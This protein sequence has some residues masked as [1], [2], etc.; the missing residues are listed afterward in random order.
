MLK[1]GTLI[2]ERYEIIEMIGSGGMANVYKAKDHKLNRFVALKVLKSEFSDDKNFVK[3]FREE[4]QACAGLSHPNIVNIYDVGNDE[5]TH[6]IV[7]ELVE[8]ITLKSYI[9]RK[10]KLEI[11]EAVGIAIQIARGMEAAHVNH[12]VHRDIKPQNIILSREGKVKVTDFGIAKAVNSNTITA[13]TMGSV[14]YLSPEQARGGYSDE[15]S[16]IYS[17]GVTLYEMLSG[18]VP[19]IGD[20]TVSVALLHIQSEAIPLRELDPEIPVS[21]ERIVQKCMQKKPERRYLTASD[22]IF[23]LR[24]SIDNPNGDFV[25]IPTTKDFDSPTILMSEEELDFIKSST[26]HTIN[27]NGG[28]NGMNSNNNR[29]I[30]D[31]EYS[32]EEYDDYEEYDDEYEAYE[33]DDFVEEDAEDIDPR[34]EKVVLIG[35]IAAAVIAAL[36]ILFMISR[37]FNLFP[38]RGETQDPTTETEETVTSEPTDEVTPSPTVVETFTMPYVLNLTHDDAVRVLK[39]KS[40]NINIYATE[41]YSDTVDKGLVMEQ[42]PSEGAEITSDTQVRLVI[43]VGK[44]EFPL[45]NVYNYTDQQAVTV[46]TDAGL[47]VTRDYQAHDTV[48]EGKVITTIPNEGTLVVKD[49]TVTVI[50]STGPDIVYV[51]VP[52]LVGLDDNVARQ[53]IDVSGLSIGTRSEEYSDQPSGTVIF[54]SKEEGEEVQEGTAINLV[55]SKGPEPTPEPTPT[56]TPTPEPSPTPTTPPTP[57][58]QDQGDNDQED[59]GTGDVEGQGDESP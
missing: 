58:P 20:N 26:N 15:K 13:T 29:G 2:N 23:D 25:V 14:H 28:Y 56:P 53:L 12:I 39:Q 35:T 31:D 33:D 38:G 30:Y 5:D 55:I 43:S 49:T 47:K 16:D 42:Y 50:I 36:V 34:M 59:P 6:F 27:S 19:F 22:L 37:F 9:E 51:T 41:D 32:D 40:E 7:M 4:A 18:R 10:G 8:G 3:K 44:E 1:P 48:E 52:R 21:I 57:T 45:P 24:K 54:Q 17:L 46:L 11:K